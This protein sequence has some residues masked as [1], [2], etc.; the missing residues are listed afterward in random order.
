[1]GGEEHGAIAPPPD[2]ALTVAGKV[3]CF[4]GTNDTGV[5]PCENL[6]FLQRARFRQINHRAGQA[7]QSTLWDYAQTSRRNDAYMSGFR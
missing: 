6:V 7:A 5:A 3:L 2:A 4:G 1:L